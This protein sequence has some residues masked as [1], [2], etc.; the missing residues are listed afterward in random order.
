[1]QNNVAYALAVEKLL[2]IVN[3]LPERCQYIRVL[4]CEL[5]RLADHYTN[6]GAA[7]LE[8]GALTA[9]IYVIEARELIWDV[10]E[11]I[12]GA[13]LT[14]SYVRIGGLSADLPKDIK[15][16][17]K[18]LFEKVDPLH[19]E[20]DKLLT[21]NRIFM[22][23]M[24]DVG[25]IS[26]E[27][28]IAYG[29]TGPCLR[30]TGV[31]YDVRKAEPYLVYDQMD[32][33][34]PVGS[35][36]DNFDIYL[37]RMEELLQSKR[38]IEQVMKNL[39]SGPININDMNIRQPSKEDVDN[40]MESMIFHFKNQIEGIQ[41]PKGEAYFATEGTNGEVGFYIVSDGGGKP[42]KCRVRPPCLSLTQAMGFR[43][44]GALLAD[45]IP[46]FDMINLIGGECDR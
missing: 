26:A 11:S 20:F 4:V 13:R 25:S 15:D 44:Q 17:V 46:T 3:K 19:V 37:I 39:P 24:R 45:I 7:A 42:Y 22:D 31:E 41:V 16:Q 28:A 32:F 27:D 30:A 23:R 5:S 6:V 34:V 38:I 14:S 21:H 8:L 33:D 9:F 12:C 36:G 18:N 43:V 1:M 10:I 35:T 29:F 2:G 40:E